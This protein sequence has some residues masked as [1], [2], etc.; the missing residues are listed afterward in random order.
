MSERVDFGGDF[1]AAMSLNQLPLATSS[2]I[3][4]EWVG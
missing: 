2:G 1:K 3:R 4:L